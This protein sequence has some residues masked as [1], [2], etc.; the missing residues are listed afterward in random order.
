MTGWAQINGGKL[1]SPQDKMALD[2]WYAHHASL[3]LDLLILWRTVLTVV[4]GDRV[5]DDAVERARLFMAQC[6][7]HTM[8]SAPVFDPR[9]RIGGD[10]SPYT[11][12]T[13]A[14]G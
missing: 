8:D 7:G 5:W 11:S 4:R 9:R 10:N 3:R 14:G 13:L 12:A 2:L 1:I 6:R